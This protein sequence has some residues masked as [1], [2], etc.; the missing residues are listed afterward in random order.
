MDRWGGVWWAA[1]VTFK[2]GANTLTKDKARCHNNHFISLHWY[3]VADLLL[4]HELLSCFC[5]RI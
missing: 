3:T 2:W 4:H 1:G 5:V